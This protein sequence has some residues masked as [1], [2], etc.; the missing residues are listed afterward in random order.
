V[1]L[2]QLRY[3][4]AV[5]DELHFSRAAHR[6]KIAQ[7]AL[8]HQIRQLERELGVELFTRTTRVVDLTPAG[9]ALAAE[10][11]GILDCTE[12]IAGA[13]RTSA[14]ARTD[15][16]R[17]GAVPGSMPTVLSGLLRTF[18]GQVPHVT[19]ELVEAGTRSQIE[20]LRAGELD[21]GIV[22]APL[23]AD[24]M[25]SHPLLEEPLMAAI[26]AEH[27]LAG[28]DRIPLAALA[29]ELLVLPRR[30][31]AP[32]L[33]DE[34]VA[35]CRR[36]G[37][38]PRVGYEVTGMAAALALVG[39]GLAAALLPASLDAQPHPGAVFVP[40]T[41]PLPTI[42]LLLIW[43]RGAAPPELTTLRDAA[44]EYVDGSERFANG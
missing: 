6:L 2:R 38:T 19:I 34:L 5:A 24:D 20:A 13:A 7:P 17:L 10:A 44:R 22:H 26:P 9:R 37:F 27:P 23:G 43:R 8:S 28:S 31:R 40:L 29:D 36:R 42:I 16:L 41:E 4:A 18:H 30:D 15:T 35:H 11:P 3:F 33:Y 14:N 21:A 25:A 39:A 12:R 32:A 1:E